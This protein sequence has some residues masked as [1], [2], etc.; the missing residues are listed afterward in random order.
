[1][2]R[3]AG[4]SD[5]DVLLSGRTVQ[6]RA[7]LLLGCS[8]ALQRN[9]HGRAF[10]QLMQVAKDGSYQRMV[11]SATTVR[12]LRHLRDSVVRCVFS[13]GGHSILRKNG[14][15]VAGFQ[16][17]YYSQRMDAR[18]KRIVKVF[19]SCSLTNNTGLEKKPHNDKQS[20]DSPSCNC[21]RK[22]CLK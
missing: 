11:L 5:R 6:R 19:L 15:K 18:N 14:N 12:H 3:V 1:M 9:L 21:L 8:E 7:Q 2:R 13:F 22:N 16:T 4:R 10:V 17:L 20:G